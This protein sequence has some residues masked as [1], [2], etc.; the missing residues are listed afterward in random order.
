[1]VS[2]N[3]IPYTSEQMEA[4]LKFNQGPKVPLTQH[5]N[6]PAEPEKAAPAKPS[7][8][9]KIDPYVQRALNE[10]GYPVGTPDG[11]LGP[12]TR[13]AI[14]KWKKDTGAHGADED[15]FGGIKGEYQRRFP[16][17]QFAYNDPRHSTQDQD[18]PTVLPAPL[19]K[20]ISSLENDFFRK[21]RK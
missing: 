20:T 2:Q 19:P 12:A 13:K 5:F 14:E 17:L 1:M 6:A 4:E 21:I 15:I 8:Y 10:L 7:G 16:G 3:L 9:G 18:K 11:V